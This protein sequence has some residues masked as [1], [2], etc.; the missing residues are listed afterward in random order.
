MNFRYVWRRSTVRDGVGRAT[1]LI[2]LFLSLFFLGGGCCG[3]LGSFRI[4]LFLLN[5]CY[6]SNNFK[7]LEKIQKRFAVFA[8][9]WTESYIQFGFI[10]SVSLYLKRTV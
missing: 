6:D 10:V 2:I 4:L 7:L 5:Y 1:N 3:S 9:I 8:D